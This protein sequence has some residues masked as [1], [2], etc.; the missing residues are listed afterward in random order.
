MDPLKKSLKSRLVGNGIEQKLKI[1]PIRWPFHYSRVLKHLVP[2]PVTTLS[3]LL[4]RDPEKLKNYRARRSMDAQAKIDCVRRQYYRQLG[5]ELHLDPPVSLT[6]KINYLKLFYEHPS[7]SRCCDKYQLKAYLR[8]KLGEGFSV[9]T[10][11]AANRFTEQDFERLPNRFVLKVNWSSGYNIVVNDKRAL[12][13]RERRMIAAQ[14]R[15]WTRP[16]SNSYYYSFYRGYEELRPVIFAEELLE[17]QFTAQEYK[18]FCFSGK[19][20]FVLIELAPNGPAHQRVCVDLTGKKLPFSFGSEPVSG[21]YTLP[22]NFAEL[23]RTAGVLAADFPFVR[24]D[25]MTDGTRLVVGEMTFYSGGGF[26]LLQ[27]PEW[28]EKLGSLLRL[29]K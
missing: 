15:E 3:I 21:R 12:S 5:K 19:P 18:V 29:S 11:F 17:R 20:E 28:D 8:E 13:R 16:Y 23:I 2:L 4:N 9:E 27:P 22:E 26:S 7:L 10:C 24:I 14:L 1:G 25:Y 6:E